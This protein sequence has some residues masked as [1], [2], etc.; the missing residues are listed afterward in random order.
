MTR[1]KPPRGT[2]SARIQ[3][4]PPLF[5]HLAPRPRPPA[6]ERRRTGPSRGRHITAGSFGTDA[7]HAPA[8]AQ[9]PWRAHHARGSSGWG[10]W[11]HTIFGEERRA[12]RFRGFSAPPCLRGFARAGVSFRGTAPIFS[13]GHGGTG[14]AMNSRH[15]SFSAPPR[16]HRVF[17]FRRLRREDHESLAN[18]P[19]TKGPAVRGPFLFGWGTRIRTWVDGVRVRS[20]TARRSPKKALETSFKIQDASEGFQPAPDFSRRLMRL[21]IILL[22]SFASQTKCIARPLGISPV[23]RPI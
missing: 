17:G 19:T 3:K 1:A 16:D 23:S 21:L 2:R 14:K 5:E 12:I 9:H 13:R 6:R 22:S 20:P 4:K 7:T 11:N 15:R 18:P 8:G 10:G